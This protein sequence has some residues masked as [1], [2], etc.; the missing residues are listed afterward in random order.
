MATKLK[1]IGKE[2][3]ILKLEFPLFS[4]LNKYKTTDKSIWKDSNILKKTRFKHFKSYNKTI[5]ATK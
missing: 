3:L 5:Q 1:L 2:K 4:N